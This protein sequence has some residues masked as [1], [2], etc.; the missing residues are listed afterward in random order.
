[1]MLICCPLKVYQFGNGWHSLPSTSLHQLLQP[2]LAD[3]PSLAQI[4]N[5]SLIFGG[6]ESTINVMWNVSFSTGTGWQL[7]EIASRPPNP[8][9]QQVA[10]AAAADQVGGRIFAFGGFQLNPF[11]SLAPPELY[12]LDV[13]TKTWNT[14]LTAEQPPPLYGHAAVVIG[15]SMFVV[16]GG[17]TPGLS[18]D[19]MRVSSQTWVFNPHSH[20]KRWRSFPS[21][22]A[23]WYWHKM[24]AYGS[25]S[26]ITV[27]GRSET[28]DGY[29]DWIATV[30][31]NNVSWT[32]LGIPEQGLAIYGHS[33]VLSSDSKSLVV[34]GGAKR[35]D[36]QY[37]GCKQT[38]EQF[39]FTTKNWSPH[40][41]G[42]KKK[43]PDGR[44]FHSAVTYGRRMVIF[45]GC[46]VIKLSQTGIP[47]CTNSADP[48]LWTWFIDLRTW[49]KIIPSMPSMYLTYLANGMVWENVV[50]LV[51]GLPRNESQVYGTHPLPSVFGMVRLCCPSGMGINEFANKPCNACP[52]G[53]YSNATSP[54]C[55]TCHEGLTT[56]NT[57]SESLLDCMICTKNYCGFGGKCS[58]LTS[59]SPTPHCECYFGFMTPGD[60]VVCSIPVFYAALVGVIVMVSVIAC[61]IRRYSQSTKRNKKLLEKKETELRLLAS[62][63]VIDSQELKL[64]ERVDHDSPGSYGE[65][66]RAEYR[67]MTVAVKKLQPFHRLDAM[68]SEFDREIEVMRSVRHPNIVLFLGGG[69]WHTDGCPFLVVEYMP[70]GSLMNILKSTDSIR[71]TEVQ[72]IR[73]AIDIAKG[74][75]YLHGLQPTRIHRD[76]K[77]ANLL[78]SERWVVKV[79][80]FG[81]ARLVKGEAIKQATRR[82]NQTPEQQPLLKP[83]NR[84][85]ADVGTL[86][87]SAPE[88]LTGEPYGTA[89]DVYRSLCCL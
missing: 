79:A 21:S 56:E 22:N 87:W 4:D 35:T 39:D 60:S 38:L 37:A 17:L 8:L 26:F 7:Q 68:E 64:K 55:Q 63:W 15:T 67:E 86:L 30:N 75:K 77:S 51:G 47:Y 48:G 40:T 54:C 76:L 19:D 49:S 66:Y 10:V 83:E 89:V 44:C 84:L 53:T 46:T 78:V 11:L 74:M 57:S 33:L 82:Y 34:Y 18:I 71:I 6:P 14:V 85:T 31:G 72:K 88:L 20:Y 24:V 58:V 50:L 16:V 62:V 81:S 70:R 80:D 29:S 23:A 32:S 36:T 52:Q 1:M 41:T 43:G 59:T 73:F 9:Q 13:K 2:G 65:V 61:V 5:Y 42:G 25:D 45:G 69:R 12:S 27:G 28:Q 3:N